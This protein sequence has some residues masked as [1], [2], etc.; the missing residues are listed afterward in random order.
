MPF[1][2]IL[3]GL[4][5]PAL[6]SRD[7]STPALSTLLG[8]AQIRWQPAR[9]TDA[10]LA[11]SFGLDG[12]IDHARL[13]RLGEDPA[14]GPLDARRRY[15]CCD[16]VHL[17]FARDALL[18]ADA[19]DLAIRRD[20]ADSLMAGLNELFADIGHFEA[21]APDRWYVSLPEAPRP[22][23]YPI[24]DVNGR[25]VQLFLPEGEDVRTWAR[26]S[27]EIEVWLYHHPVNAAREA[28]GQ[29]TIN[30]VWLWGSGS[31]EA[32]PQAPAPQ[33]FADA[34]F[35]RGL[36]RDAGIQ[37]SPAEPIGS[38]SGAALAL[39][40]ALERPALFQNPTAWQAALEGLDSNC[41][42]PLLGAL[43]SGRVDSLRITAPGDKHSLQ[44]DIQAKSLWKFWRRPQSLAELL[45][46]APA[47]KP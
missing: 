17:H 45:A 25:P 9:S 6:S 15:L 32:R 24:A 35:A 2:L 7:S 26:L 13:R 23:F 33:I 1:H 34:P 42:A 28:A 4:L 14:A 36:A 10:V 27:N 19:T 5:A 37:P 30:G 38:P 20:E 40:N 43:K 29:R 31:G 39:V 18:L 8:H 46:Q 44:L 41:L 16:P 11:E 22:R 21:P 3:P 12:E 47:T